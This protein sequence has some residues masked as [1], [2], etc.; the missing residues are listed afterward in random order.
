VT[1]L[2]TLALGLLLAGCASTPAA[3]LPPIPCPAAPPNPAVTITLDPE[4][5]E[6]RIRPWRLMVDYI[7]G[8]QVAHAECRA[9]A[10]PNP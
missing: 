7:V 3:I 6:A 10:E 4:T 9:A 1:R 8:L 2:V 5:D